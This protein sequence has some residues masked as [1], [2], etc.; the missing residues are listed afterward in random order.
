MQRL[1]INFIPDIQLGPLTLELIH[2]KVVWD[3]SKVGLARETAIGIAKH[4]EKGFLFI[5]RSMDIFR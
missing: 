2:D 4:S 1:K 5:I 3:I